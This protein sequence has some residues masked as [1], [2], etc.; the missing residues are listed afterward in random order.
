M[1][2]NKSLSVASL[3][4]SRELVQTLT[5]VPTH[6]M[7]LQELVLVLQRRLSE[8]EALEAMGGATDLERAF[9]VPL[10]DTLR[11]HANAH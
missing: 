1:Q 6:T 5:G 10:I 2:T 3:L 8:V 9:L 4:D 11:A 7:T